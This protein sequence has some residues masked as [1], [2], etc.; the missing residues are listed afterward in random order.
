MLVNLKFKYLQ[1]RNR[2]L[3]L[4]I[5]VSLFKNLQTSALFGVL[6]GKEPAIFKKLNLVQLKHLSVINYYNN[7]VMK[8]ESWE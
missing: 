6:F 4:K 8:I 7:Q 2:C 3:F 5:S 1:V